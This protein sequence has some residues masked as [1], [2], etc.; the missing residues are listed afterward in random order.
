VDDALRAELDER[1]RRLGHP[2]LAAWAGLEN[3]EERVDGDA[4]I[5]PV[6]LERLREAS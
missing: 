6:V 1:L 2:D 5:D 4:E 3:L